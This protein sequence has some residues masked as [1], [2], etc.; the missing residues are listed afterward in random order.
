[1]EQRHII[2]LVAAIL[3]AIGI[4]VLAV[5]YPISKGGETAITAPVRK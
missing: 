2:M 3:A 5:N 1:M 4:T